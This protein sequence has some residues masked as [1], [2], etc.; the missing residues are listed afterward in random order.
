MFTKIQGLTDIHCHILPYVDDGARNMDEAVEMVRMQAEQGVS[1]IYLTPH[2]R[3]GLFETSS[4]VIKHWFEVLK[5]EAEKLPDAPKL[6]LG[7]EYHADEYLKNLLLRESDTDDVPAL[8]GNGKGLLLEFSDRHGEEEILQYIELVK[9]HGFLPI[10]AHAERYQIVSESIAV[11]EK[12]IRQG[13]WIQVNAASILGDEGREAKR[14]TLS[15][16]KK[17]FV[18]LIGTDAHRTDN[19]IPNLMNCAKF[20][21]R[22]VSKEQYERIFF[23]NPGKMNG[24]K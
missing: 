13:A 16:L 2:H 14:L 4:D 10:V 9:S 21:R 18:H 22:K 1:C 23:E 15:L 11:V 12:M 8:M 24:S 3:D 7:R 17:D 19:R 20:V 6:L 5:K